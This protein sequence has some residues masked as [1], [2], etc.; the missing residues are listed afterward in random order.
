[1]MI[2]IIIWLSKLNVKNVDMNGFLE[3]KY[4]PHVLIAKPENGT[5]KTRNIKMA[6]T[7]FRVVR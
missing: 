7:A 1:M 3:Q 6:K 4:L 2:K 5:K